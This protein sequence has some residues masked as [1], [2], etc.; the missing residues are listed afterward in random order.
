MGRVGCN[1]APNPV[2]SSSSLQLSKLPP[3]LDTSAEAGGNSLVLLPF[4]PGGCSEVLPSHYPLPRPPLPLGLINLSCPGV[5]LCTAPC[6]E[7]TPTQ[8]PL[9]N[10][11]T[12][13]H[14]IA[15]AEAISPSE[16]LGGGQ[17]AQRR[18]SESG[19]SSGAHTC[20]LSTPCAVCSRGLGPPDAP[21]NLAECI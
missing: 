2:T 7:V 14:A 11:G 9:A 12:Q 16:H 17:L 15:S 13:A 21:R 6:K 8:L 4:P 1:T 20:I 3:P 10:Q 19:H 18:S 5:Q